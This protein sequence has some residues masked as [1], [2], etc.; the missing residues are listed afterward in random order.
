MD[1]NNHSWSWPPNSPDLT[2]TCV[3]SKNKQAEYDAS[4]LQVGEQNNI[5]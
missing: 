5:S 3:D 2:F 1:N 4:E